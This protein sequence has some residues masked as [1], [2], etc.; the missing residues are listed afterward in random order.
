MPV[1]RCGLCEWHHAVSLHI[2]GVFNLFPGSDAV[3]GIGTLA[4]CKA[5]EVEETHSGYF[6]LMGLYPL[7]VKNI[8][9]SLLVDLDKGLGIFVTV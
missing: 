8:R 9:I 2:W 7:K 4:A 1:Y 3:L 6:A 5:S